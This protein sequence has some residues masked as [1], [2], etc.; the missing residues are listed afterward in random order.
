MYTSRAWDTSSSAIRCAT[1]CW[2]STTFLFPLAT[3]PKMTDHQKILN[4]LKA[5][6]KNDDVPA[7]ED[8]LFDSGYIDSFALADLVP[9][10]EKEFAITIP[11]SDVIPRKF[12][13]V[14]RIEAYIQSRK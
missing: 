5:V 10:L 1:I 11:D 3:R 12:E 4:A 9:E 2:T 14:S 6:S 7:D 13:S 8:S